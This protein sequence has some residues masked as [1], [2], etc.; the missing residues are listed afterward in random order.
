MEFI[1]PNSDFQIKH[2]TL[3]YFISYGQITKRD[4]PPQFRE[5]C[6]EEHGSQGNSLFMEAGHS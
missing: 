1:L 6:K 5:K 2:F 4:H 3:F